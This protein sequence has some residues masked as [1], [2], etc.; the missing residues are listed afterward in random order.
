MLNL[1]DLIVIVFAGTQ[2]VEI[3]HHGSIFGPGGYLPLRPRAKRWAEG[4]NLL[5]KFF[6]SLIGCPFC[7]TPWVCVGLV[8]G[9]YFC[10][11]PVKLAICGF[12]IARGAN[13]L[14]DLTHGIPT[15]S[16]QTADENE[17][18]AGEGGL[19]EM[20]ETL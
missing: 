5:L 7:L 8:F 4:R 19:E 14:N 20:S 13:I 6:G 12:A 15:R 18:A 2:V 17:V 9:W 11:I 3:I 10:G 1:I 16:P